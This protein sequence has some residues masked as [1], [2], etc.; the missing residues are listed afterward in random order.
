MEI[1]NQLN[2]KQKDAVTT[3]NQH[4]RIIAG[5][6]SG[7]TRV[8]MARIAYLVKECGIWPNRILAITFTNKATNE[9]KER[10]HAILNDDAYMVR[11]STIHSLCVRILREDAQCIDYPSSFTILDS[12]DQKVILRP[13]YKQMDIQVKALPFSKVLSHISGYKTGGVDPE[14]A[15]SMAMD[16][17]QEVIAC[18]YKKYEV[19]RKEMRAMDFDDLLLEAHRLLK[20]DETVRLKWQRRLD[21]IHVDEFQD[22]DYVQ[23]EIIRYL[24]RKNAFLCVVG[25]PDQT[26]YTWRGASV[27]IIMRF[28]K[29]FPSCKTVILNQNYRSIQPILDASNELIRFNKNR[30]QKDLFSTI[31]GNQKIVMN[32]SQDDSE[33][34]LYVARQILELKKQ[35]YDF[36]DMAILYRSNFSSRAFEQV[37]RKTGIPYRIYGGIRFYE[38]QEIKD[39]LSYLKLC[40]KPDEKDPEQMSLDLAIVRIINRP[41]RKIGEKTIEKLQ[42]QAMNQN[43][44][45]LEVM[46]DAQDVS[47]TIHNKCKQFVELIES[48]RSHR[49]DYSLEDFFQ[50]VLEETGYLK[51]LEDENEEDRIENLKELKQD[52]AMNLKENPDYSLEEYLQE[53]AL[54]TDKS[55]EEKMNSISLMTVHAAKGLEFKAVFIVNF[56]ES[57]FPSAR[58]IQEGGNQSLEEER[59]LCYVAMT[60]AKEFL[61]ISWNRGYSYMLETYKT[62]SRFVLEIPK[63]YTNLDKEESPKEAVL[64]KPKSRVRYRK[65]DIVEHSVYGQGVIIKVEGNIATIAFERKYGIKKLNALHPSLKKR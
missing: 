13:F 16:E 12:D 36:S 40:T 55:Q 60:R 50:F 22:V 37:L 4:V 5:A 7:K 38:R 63:Q 6:G 33:E 47:S 3:M 9:M 28:D 21:Y 24:T 42:Q 34:P 30:I 20:T 15:F 2:D 56:N 25:D 11:I 57:V 27:D 41:R 26:I 46:K 18:L 31:D 61:C 62:P 8:L 54:F 53:I 23:Y 17:T 58:S 65:G 29:D 59:R 45:L 14:M 51:M 44:N 48:L 10:L 43:K 32:Q 64:E 19:K 1:L 52:I 39:M 49:E 35:G